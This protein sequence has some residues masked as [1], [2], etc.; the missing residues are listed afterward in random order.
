M[1]CYCLYCDPEGYAEAQEKLRKG[2]VN[3]ES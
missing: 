2:E 3:D 1:S